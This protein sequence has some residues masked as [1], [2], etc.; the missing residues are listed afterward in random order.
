M[1]GGD[2]CHCHAFDVRG[3]VA[4]M[5]FDRSARLTSVLVASLLAA[6]A[7]A[8]GPS[9]EATDVPAQAPTTKDE[10]RS[11][12]PLRVTKPV[13][14][15]AFAPAETTIRGAVKGKHLADG[16]ECE[17]CHSDVAAGFQASAHALA[18][19]NNPIY[20]GSIDRFRADAGNKTSR[21][22]GGCHDI[23]LLVDGG[24]D[25][26]VE[27]S[28]N[29]AH[30]GI[31]CKTCHGIVAARIDG[32]GSYELSADPI[33]VPV[34][35]DAQSIVVHKAGA[36]SS[37]LRTNALCVSCHRAF[38]HE[39]TGNAHFLIGQDDVT[40]WQQ[41]AYAGSRVHL[42]DEEV[43]MQDCRGCHMP[44][45]RAD[46]NDPAAKN[47]TIASHRFVGAHTWLAAMRG[48]EKTLALTRT[49]LE[50]A[51]SIDI[52]AVI[53]ADGK[54]ALPAD[55]APVKAGERLTIDVAL[56]N[57]RVGHRFPGGVMDAQDTWIEV[58]VRDAKDSFIAEAGLQHER[59]GD[60][61]TAHRL[62]SLAVGDDGLPRLERQTEQFRAGVFNHTML[63]RA[64]QV[65]EYA[66]DVP[67]DVAF[68]LRVVARLRHRTRNLHV[69]R[70][71]CEATRDARGRAFQK[72]G[73]KLDA[74]AP[75][76]ITT[77]SE[78]ETWIGAGADK[79]RADKPHLP[80]WRRLY[81][82]GLGLVG[83]L[84][85]RRDEA[86]PSFLAAL[87]ALE[88]TADPRP[89]AVVMAGLAMLAGRQGR[90]DEATRWIDALSKLAPDHPAIP[91]LRGEALSQVWRF[92]QAAGP[93]TDAAERAPADDAAWV[94]VAISR[95]SAGDP[96]GGLD[97]AKR[98]LVF[99]PRDHDLLR[100]QALSLGTLGAT[101]KETSAAW[102]AWQN[103]RPA[104]SIPSVKAK[105]SKNVP[106]CALERSPVH[107]HV[108]RS[109]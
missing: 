12:E 10:P 39:G 81:D 90:V 96:R 105:C 100:I 25:V 63:P 69:Q 50:G 107:V 103:V 85:E 67:A 92:E 27:P 54:R 89:K 18:S 16:G 86:G 65:V 101:E 2:R 97:A 38:L 30:A 59:T 56:R 41:S 70:V 72:N 17:G 15:L 68:P 53:A 35:G 95:A 48:D 60:D 47:G 26:A 9:T 29:R 98:G 33:P 55:G 76:P 83:A 45:E 21:F 84:Q 104:D 42:L 7:C 34:Q 1:S 43:P 3:T 37:V 31:G 79:L 109:K 82:H 49:M 78:T 20:R 44:R 74:C 4:S 36:A 106:G 80:T 91:Y 51:V 75:Q 5:R 87:S 71:A 23:A 13:S 52:A 66:L 73:V 40:P 62:R 93:L 14:S 22:C 77:I 24:M 61:P 108:M 99:Q 46:R 28:D 57:E 32:N 8:R 58:E 6:G 19:F 11:A 94:M 88:G 102:E 64:A